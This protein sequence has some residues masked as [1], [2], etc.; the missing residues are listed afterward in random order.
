M[1]D[2][3]KTPSAPIHRLH[4]GGITASVFSKEVP[5]KDG[6]SKVLY[7]VTVSRGYTNAKGDRQYTTTLRESDLLPA[8]QSLAKAFELIAETRKVANQ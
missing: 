7:K 8:A 3:A 6:K 1:A 4:Y 2:N 5:I